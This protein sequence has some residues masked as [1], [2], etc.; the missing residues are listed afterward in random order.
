MHTYTHTHRMN[1]TGL[2]QARILVAAGP[3][4][5]ALGL[6]QL[7]PLNPKAAEL[8]SVVVVPEARGR[9]VGAA[10]VRR[11]VGGGG[12]SES[13][14][15]EDVGGGGGVVYL[16]T[17]SRRAAFYTRAAGFEAVPLASAP[18]EMLL[19]IAAGTVAARLFANDSLILM[20]LRR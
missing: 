7:V 12:G 3:C 10:L 5:R 18:P 9:G 14:G 16:T 15:S 2:V 13:G 4:G 1:P 17:I 11:L 6:G 20:A 19:E 8:R